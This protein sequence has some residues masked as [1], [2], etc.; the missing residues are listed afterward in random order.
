MNEDEILRNR[1]R[2]CLLGGAAG[3]AL[4]YP[5]EFMSEGSICS[6]YGENGITSLSEAGDP[7]EFSD[8]TQMSLFCVNGIILGDVWTAYLEWLGTQ[9]DTSRMDPNRPKTWLYEVKELH[10]L[11]APGGTCLSSLRSSIFGGTP[12]D[13][14]NNSKGCG[15]VMRAAPWGLYGDRDSDPSVIFR[16]AAEDGALT[17]G[18]PLGYLSSGMLALI[19]WYIVHLHPERDHDLGDAILEASRMADEKTNAELLPIIEK[20]VELARDGSVSDLSAVHALGEGWVAEEAL[21][22]AVFAAVRY[23]NDFKKALVC[24]VNHKGDSDSTGA[25]CGNILGAWLGEN[26]IVSSLDF[27]HLEMRSLIGEAAEDLY[28]FTVKGAPEKGTDPVWDGKYRRG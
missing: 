27:E 18:H 17:H 26:V 7:A 24:A 16:N 11:R 8:D 23:Q 6:R 28:T 1:F 4:G 25:V 20:A 12:E 10:S 9:H 3:D 19:L 13:P 2:G 21:A 22:I 5:V 14:V 15:T